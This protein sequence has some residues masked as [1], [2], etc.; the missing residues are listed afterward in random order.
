MAGLVDLDFK[1]I[2]EG[3]GTAAKDIRT[4]ITGVD[5]T[6]AGQINLALVGVEEK[7]AEAQPIIAQ[8]Q[9]ADRTSARTLGAEYVKAGKIN[10]RQNI[11]AYLAVLS[12]IGFVIGLFIGKFNPDTRDLMNIVLGGLLK[13]V[14]DIY[15][16]DFGGS[17]GGEQSNGLLSGIISKFKNQ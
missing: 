12:L 4:A 11:L 15:G 5:P 6:I 10:W 17:L 9:A 2:F 8:A 1:G 14:Y 7:L 3:F 16:Y 13:I